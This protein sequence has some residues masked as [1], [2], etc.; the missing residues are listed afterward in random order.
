MDEDLQLLQ[1]LIVVDVVLLEQSQRVLWEMVH[2]CDEVVG[3]SLRPDL[4]H[5]LLNGPVSLEA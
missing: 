5:D 2:D 4:K 1:I 3:A